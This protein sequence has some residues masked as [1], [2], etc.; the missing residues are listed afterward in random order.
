MVSLLQRQEQEKK[1]LAASVYKAWHSLKE[2]ERNLLMPYDGDLEKAP[3]RIKRIFNK[4]RKAY[5]LEWGSKGKH[6]IALKEKHERERE[7]LIN[8]NQI[9]DGIRQSQQRAKDKNQQKEL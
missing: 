4:D 6:A 9:L 5:W 2:A 8:R 3:L 7:S 1:D